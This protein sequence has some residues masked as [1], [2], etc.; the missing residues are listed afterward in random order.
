MRIVLTLLLMAATA[1]AWGTWVRIGSTDTAVHYIDPT[2]IRKDGN[3][4][5]IWAMQDMRQTSPD[6]VMSIRL[7][8]EYDCAEESFRYLS[9]S[10]HSGPMAGGRILLADN[11]DDEWSF[12]PPG[13]KPSIIEK[14]VCAP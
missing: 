1:S 6:G 5:R 10:A 11:L 2:T 4:R 12:R 13:T 9:V 3:L 7:F 8:E 14:I